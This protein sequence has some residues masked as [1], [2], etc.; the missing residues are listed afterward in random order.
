MPATDPVLCLMGL[1]SECLNVA[2]DIRDPHHLVQR[3]EQLV[4]ELSEL[5]PSVP[6]AQGLFTGYGRVYV[7][8]AHLELAT[9]ECDNPFTLV[10]VWERLQTL[11]AQAVRRLHDRGLPLVLANCNHS[12]LLHERAA[13][14]GTHGNYLVAEP[15]AGLAD[16]LLPFL[17]TRVYT[18]AG[19]LHWPS[20]ELLASTR[21]HVLDRERGGCTTRQRAIHSTGRDEPLTSQPQRYGFRYHTLLDDGV[22]SQFSLLLQHGTLALVLKTVIDDPAAVETLPVPGG[23]AG[24]RSFWMQAL[25]RFNRLAIPGELPRVDPLVCHIQDIYLAAVDRYVG[26]TPNAPAWMSQVLVIWESTLEAM[27]RKDHAWLGRR[28]DPWI[29]HRVFSAYLAQGGHS[30]SDLPGCEPLAAALALVNQDYHEFCS[31]NSVFAQLE[32]SDELTHRVVPNVPPGSEIEPFVPEVV[33]RGRARARWIREQVG[34]Q[35]VVADWM[36]LEDRAAGLQWLL[37]DPRAVEL[38]APVL[39]SCTIKRVGGEM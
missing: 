17:V 33:T 35:D 18:G 34:Q 26:R 12:G 9:V 24:R 11:V 39:T 4:R 8:H 14:W 3:C 19:G 21:A 7:D 28:L 37:D 36:R 38:V 27:R 5:I 32:A 29:K 22:R 16:R 2:P 25:Q 1:E 23:D 6:G 30:W 15:P 10:S 13:T 20:G 31:P